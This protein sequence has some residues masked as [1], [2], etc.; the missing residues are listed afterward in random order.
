MTTGDDRYSL[1]SHEVGSDLHHV[2]LWDNHADEPVSVI[3][4]KNRLNRGQRV[5]DAGKAVAHALD[6]PV[7]TIPTAASNDAPTSK[8]YVIYDENHRLLR[9]GHTALKM[10]SECR[11][12]LTR[13]SAARRVSGASHAHL[14]PVNSA[15]SVILT[16]Q[17]LLLTLRLV[18]L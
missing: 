15:P 4:A 1:Q 12:R 17:R 10:T 13:F 8:N 6:I 11:L 14:Q 3:V 16:S 7:V 5:I 2:A 9:V 18:W